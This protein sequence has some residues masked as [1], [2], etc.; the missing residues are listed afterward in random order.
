MSELCHL[1]Q[2]SVFKGGYSFLQLSSGMKG[3]HDLIFFPRA[4][5]V[6]ERLGERLWGDEQ[7][8]RGKDPL[9]VPET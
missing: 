1:G 7:E 2:G 9:Q 8:R 3:G 4:T 5:S 6:T